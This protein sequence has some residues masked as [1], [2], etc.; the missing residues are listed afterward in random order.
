MSGS[1]K[2]T[3][4]KK[5]KLRRI[6]HWVKYNKKLLIFSTLL[7]MALVIGMGVW[8]YR[9]H[10]LQASRH[11][12]AGNSVDMGNGY[13]YITYKGKNYQYNSLITTVLYAGLDS[14]GKLK[15]DANYSNKERADSISLV[16]LDKKN[17]KM[18]ILAINRD[19][20]TKVRRYSRSGKDM[21]TYVTH[22]GY[23]Y[24]YGDGGE[25]S[26]E[27]L[28]EAVS[29]LLFD[30]PIDEY[31]VTNQSSMPY[32]NNLVGGVTVEIPNNDL[33][34]LYPEM[35]QGATVKLNDSNITDYLHYRDTAV[36]FSNEGRIE[37][38]EAYITAYVDQL[39]QQLEKDLDGTWNRVTEMQDYLQTSITRNKYIQLV[40]LLNAVTFT[41]DNYYHLE[42][43]DR[44]GDLHDEFYY[45]E[46]A[47]HEKVIELFY[48]EI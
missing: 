38:Q 45:D 1:R 43:E 18:T 29:N 9:M 48:E 16:V 33:A 3:G 46:D 13:R 39:R 35:K 40:N 19:T 17:K 7:G 42:G 5:R 8:G 12:T 21:G 24:S 20:M 2:H 28:R 41:G 47:L 25:V 30:I 14:E 15:Q 37:R 10:K 4:N 32:I 36:D 34:A 11:V 22:L 31:A 44:K 27:N 23:A 6:R 26:C